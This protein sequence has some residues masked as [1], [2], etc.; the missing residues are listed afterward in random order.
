MHQLSKQECKPLKFQP[1]ERPLHAKCYGSKIQKR[2]FWWL[3][4]WCILDANRN[5][6]YKK[7]LC[8]LWC[9]EDTCEQSA[10]ENCNFLPSSIQVNVSQITLKSTLFKKCIFPFIP[11][12]LVVLL[13]QVFWYSKW[14]WA[15]KVKLCTCI[16][17][18]I[19]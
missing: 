10:V 14:R 2:A 16:N 1:V 5:F 17:K 7:T 3:H 18:T 6:I 19:D 11:G 8:A 13:A 4:F 9:R 15:V 12:G